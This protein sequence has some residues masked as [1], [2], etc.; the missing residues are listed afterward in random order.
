MLIRR[1]HEFCVTSEK[2]K[3]EPHEKKARSCESELLQLEF[4][5]PESDAEAQ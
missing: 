5:E 4:L 1:I 2:K 3:T